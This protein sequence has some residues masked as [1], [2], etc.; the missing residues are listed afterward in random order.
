[1]GLLPAQV[2]GTIHVADPVAAQAKLDLTA[3][4]NDAAG[5]S[6]NVITVS[7]NIGG[8]TLAPGLYRSASTLE[9]S[10]GNLTL[11]AR[12]TRMLFGSSR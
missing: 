9:I 10:S 1:M 2:N 6:V 4:F 8:Q 11:D 3:A 5:R 12:A 7:G